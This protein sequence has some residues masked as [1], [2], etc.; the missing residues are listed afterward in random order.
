MSGPEFSDLRPINQ[1]GIF[2]PFEYITLTATQG[3]NFGKIWPVVAEDGSGLDAFREGTTLLIYLEVGFPRTQEGPVINPNGVY[4][5]GLRIKPW[6]LRSAVEFRT[7]GNP[8]MSGNPYGVMGGRLPPGP[9]GGTPYPSQIDTDVFRGWSIFDQPFDPLDGQQ[10]ALINANVLGNRN[11][12]LPSPKRLDTVPFALGS[13]PLNTAIDRTSDSVLLDDI[14]YV[15]LPNPGEA[16][17]DASPWSANLP[18]NLPQIPPNHRQ[19][20]VFTYPAFGRCLGVSFEI[21]LASLA[22][23]APFVSAGIPVAPGGSY[24]SVRIGYRS[25]VTHSI[26]QERVG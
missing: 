26:I 25:G 8:A 4:V 2:S 7:P 24:P 19:N 21:T 9:P 5:S 14:W 6:W 11:V 16:P 13:A 23:N 20:K 22:N 10:F 12:W 17:F 3:V 1:Q 18:A 15:P